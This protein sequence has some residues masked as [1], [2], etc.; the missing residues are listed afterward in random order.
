CLII[1]ASYPAVLFT[2]R[3]VNLTSCL[4]Q[5]CFIDFK[6][7]FAVSSLF[8]TFK[9]VFIP[10]HSVLVLLYHSVILF[11][12]APFV[13]I[14]VCYPLLVSSSFSL[15][16]AGFFTVLSGPKLEPRKIGT[17]YP[18]AEFFA[19]GFSPPFVFASRTPRKSRSP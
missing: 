10:F 9:F 6:L 1:T 13:A 15:I 3:H 2:R 4:L 5:T 8:L 17:Y 16:V 7:L 18:V 11:T 19:G 12:A 14:I